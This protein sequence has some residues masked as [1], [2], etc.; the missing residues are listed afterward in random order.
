M[1]VSVGNCPKWKGV[2]NPEK[3]GDLRQYWTSTYS[4]K[5][6]KDIRKNTVEEKKTKNEATTSSSSNTKCID[7][8]TTNDNKDVITTIEEKTEDKREDKTELHHK[9]K[10]S[11][12]KEETDSLKKKKDRRIGLYPEKIS[13]EDQ[14]KNILLKK[15]EA[16]QLH[17]QKYQPIKKKA[18]TKSYYNYYSPIMSSLVE[19][20]EEQGPPKKKVVS[21]VECDPA[22]KMSGIITNNE[23]EITFTK[24][25]DM[26]TEEENE[27]ELL[28]VQDASEADFTV[29]TD[30]KK[31][32]IPSLKK[33]KVSEEEVLD[34]Y[35]IAGQK[36]LE[37]DYNMI[38]EEVSRVWLP[39][40]LPPETDA[41]ET[42]IAN[43]KYTMP[44][45]VRINVPKNRKGFNK[46]RVMV[47]LLRLCQSCNQKHMLLH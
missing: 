44:V 15:F 45:T 28:K 36:A 18:D 25:S 8:K 14:I 4:E 35:D 26:E 29:V 41:F 32:A 46:Q 17:K 39:R 9:L 24:E 16:I 43:T 13:K 34:D 47:A 38:H 2:T 27:V 33:S 37:K 7:K 22:D 10:K 23:E 21:E 30:K 1:K 19:D 11:D 3:G 42:P 31:K 12:S 20:Y 5:I 6:E 40:T